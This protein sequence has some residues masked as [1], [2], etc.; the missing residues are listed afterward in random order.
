MAAS[1]SNTKTPVMQ[2]QSIVYPICP[3]CRYK[4]TPRFQGIKYSGTLYCSL[5]CIHFRNTP[6]DLSTYKESENK[7]GQIKKISADTKKEEDNKQKKTDEKK[8]DQ[9]K[10][11]LDKARETE[12]DKEK[13]RDE[14]PKKKHRDDS[15]REEKTRKKKN[16]SEDDS[17]RDEKPKKKKTLGVI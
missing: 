7:Q 2:I 3:M 8:E 11:K 6:V 9:D 10:P 13:H 1:N 17:D 16:R 15:D 5:H 14:K 4:I 12:R